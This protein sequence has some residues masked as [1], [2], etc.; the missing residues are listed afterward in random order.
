M[1]YWS[2]RH[3]LQL[4]SRKYSHSKDS[5]FES[6]QSRK[7]QVF[8]PGNVFQ[9]W[10]TTV[11]KKEKQPDVLSLLKNWK[12]SKVRNLKRACVWGEGFSSQSSLALISSPALPFMVSIVCDLSVRRVTWALLIGLTPTDRRLTLEWSGQTM[13]GTPATQQN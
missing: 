13:L 7:T 3:C 4:Y 6:S 10:R 8:L 2:T 1:F 5:F 9:E 11:T 12:K